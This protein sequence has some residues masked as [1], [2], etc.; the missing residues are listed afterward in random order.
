LP[1]AGG[2]PIDASGLLIVLGAMSLRTAK[3]INR[4]RA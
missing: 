1:V 3:M 4:K 2:S